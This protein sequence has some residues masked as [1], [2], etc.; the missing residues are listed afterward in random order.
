MLDAKAKPREVK[1]RNKFS[2]IRAVDNMTE[3][4]EHFAAES[5][6]SRPFSFGTFGE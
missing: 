3:L 5:V 1:V 4:T 6:I 2:K